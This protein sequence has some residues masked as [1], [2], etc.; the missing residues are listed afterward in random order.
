MYACYRGKR[1]LPNWLP[2]DKTA[3]DRRVKVA[4]GQLKEWYKAG[5]ILFSHKKEIEKEIYLKLRDLFSI[6]VDLVFYDLTSTY[7]AQREPKGDIKRHG[8]SRDEEKLLKEKQ[9]EGI[10]ILL[11]N[12]PKIPAYDALF[13]Y[14]N[15]SE[16]KDFFR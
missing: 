1:V 7:F 4:W 10:Y 14:K 5:D 9:I 11:T 6:N 12:D 16:V 8:Y 13:T 3:K 15:L 2:E